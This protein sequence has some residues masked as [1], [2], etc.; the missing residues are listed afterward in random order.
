MVFINVHIRASIDI[1]QTN[2]NVFLY[3]I[4][5]NPIYSRKVRKE[6]LA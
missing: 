6:S 2:L 5:N 4:N 3:F 1:K